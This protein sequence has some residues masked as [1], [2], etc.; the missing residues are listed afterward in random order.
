MVEVLCLIHQYNVIAFTIEFLHGGRIDH[1]VE[2]N[3]QLIIE[4]LGENATG[5]LDLF[6]ESLGIDQMTEMVTRVAPEVIIILKETDR[7]SPLITPRNYSEDL[8]LLNEK[9]DIFKSLPDLLQF[10]F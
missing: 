6:L 1:I 7:L 9:A 2:V 3:L 4:S 5:D 8:R 10:E